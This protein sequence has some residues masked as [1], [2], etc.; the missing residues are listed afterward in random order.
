MKSCQKKLF[1]TGAPYPCL[2]CCP[3]DIL[4]YTDIFSTPEWRDA[5]CASSLAATAVPGFLPSGVWGMERR[6]WRQLHVLLWSFF[7]FLKHSQVCHGD[8]S[9]KEPEKSDLPSPHTHSSLFPVILDSLVLP[10]VTVYFHPWVPQKRV[11]GLQKK[12]IS[13]LASR[14]NWEPQNIFTSR[15]F[16]KDADCYFKS[17]ECDVC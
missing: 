15:K 13:H 3:A 6:R 11:G 4:S 9:L 2:H 16:G 14:E 17:I 12:P 10:V 8:Q 5:F 7:A 1:D